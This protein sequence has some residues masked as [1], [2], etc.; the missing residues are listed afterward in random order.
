MARFRSEL[1]ILLSFVL[2][3]GVI[4][5]AFYHKKQFYPSIVY[6]T[7]SNSSMAVS[8]LLVSWSAVGSDFT[9]FSFQ[10]LYLQ[11]FVVALLVGKVMNKIF[12]GQL[13]AI[14]ME[15]SSSG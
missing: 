4:L 14:E 8:S 9:E 15:V 6:L 13:R 3:L 10:V 11:A 2:T 5:N 12:F 1:A 7:K